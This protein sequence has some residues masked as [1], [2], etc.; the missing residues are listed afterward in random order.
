MTS[1]NI[2]IAEEVSN[3]LEFAYAKKDNG[4]SDLFNTITDF[5]E[6][7]HSELSPNELSLMSDILE[8]LLS[9][10]ETNVRKKLADRLAENENAPVDLI[11][12]LANDQSEV[13]ASVLSLSNLLSDKELIKIIRHKTVQH[14]L[15]IA[16]RE[17]LA[18]GVCRELVSVG[19]TKTLVMLLNNHSARIDNES[20]AI[21]VEKSKKN[22]PI[23]PPLIERP[24]L[25]KEMAAKMY[26]WVS[27]SL[28]Q[29]ILTNL[30]L[31]E[32]DIDNL[33]KSAIEDVTEE[34][35]SQVTTEKSEVLLVNKLHKA[36][37]LTPSF[38]MKC[39]NQGQISLFEIAFSKMINVPRNIMRTFL[40]DRGSESLAV[41]CCAA[42][43]DRSVF[44][45]IYQLTRE[46]QNVDSTLSDEEIAKA[47]GH[48]KSLDKK[49]AHS[50]IQKWVAEATGTSIF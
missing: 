4:R 23:Q 13:A 15:G 7:R 38:L 44:L 1:N 50:I 46:A 28:K 5:L 35:I 47:F 18:S 43:I 32:A 10:V 41:I 26:Q 12:L 31:S 30:N 25:P 17:R 42:A 49:K 27:L 16:S 37:R 8:K 20:L 24:D 34:E 40:Y 48:F 14:Q 45:T 11:I 6:R 22:V 2:P 33:L 39:L 9:D 19:N 36:S 21:L 3:L 29:S